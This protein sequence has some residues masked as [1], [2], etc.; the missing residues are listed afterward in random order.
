[1]NMSKYFLYY[2]GLNA[3]DGIEQ[4]G[5]AVSDDLRTWTRPHQK[6]IIPLGSAGEVDVLQTSNP[7]VLMR[8]GLFRMW[9]QGRGRDGRLNICYAESSDG[10][11]WRA[12]KGAVLAPPLQTSGY[13]AGYQQPHV[14]FDQELRIYRMWFTSQ[15]GARSHISYAES[16]DGLTWGDVTE[17]V[18]RPEVE[19]EGQLLYYPFVTRSETGFELLYTAR[20]KGKIWMLGHA[21]SID[22][23]TWNKDNDNPVLPKKTS[24][25][26]VRVLSRYVKGIAPRSL[27]SVYGSGSP[28]TIVID[29]TE[30]LFTHDS[31]AGYRLSISH[32]TRGENGGWLP[33]EYGVLELGA[34]DWDRYFQA[35]PFIVQV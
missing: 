34:S 20:S 29:G 3:A 30:H 9:Y 13:R 4:I 2:A 5:V 21:S 23:I 19:W 15:D 10:L 28:F 16:S 35:D 11:T 24:P 22:G 1:M 17:G 6:P 31:G 27:R 33:L 25:G 7:C 32:Y 14:L 18:V 12:R 26:L 8:D